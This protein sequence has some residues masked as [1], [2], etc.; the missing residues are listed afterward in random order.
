M[1]TP[2]SPFVGR[3]PKPALKRRQSELPSDLIDWDAPEI[4]ELEKQRII[5]EDHI[6][7]ITE[8]NEIESIINE[9]IF[10]VAHEAIAEEYQ[11]QIKQ[12]DDELTKERS[13]VHLLL[14]QIKMSEEN[15]KEY[16]VRVEDLENEV[17][18]QRDIISTLNH[19]RELWSD[20]RNNLRMEIEDLNFR[21][22]EILC[23]LNHNV[24]M[25]VQKKNEVKG[26]VDQLDLMKRRLAHYKKLAK[27][28]DNNDDLQ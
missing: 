6:R 8:D 1:A 4:P 18:A 19:E 11:H 12:L 14:G 13:R 25:F 24:E 3:K 27:N 10:T 15:S 26:I 9:Q 21:N 2:F 5:Y 17:T 28:K 22:N 20:E 7:E 16:E 23:E